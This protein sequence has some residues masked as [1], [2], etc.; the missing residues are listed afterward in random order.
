MRK[1]EIVV[2]TLACEPLPKS[3]GNPTTQLIESPGRPV[4]GT[5][6][7]RLAA[8][9]NQPAPVQLS[10]DAVQMEKVEEVEEAE[11]P[12]RRFHV[13]ADFN[14]YAHAFECRGRF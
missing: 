7:R 2:G 13:R 3:R 12:H 11:I 8:L 5:E 1:I 6:R 14:G 10:P 4:D 9:S